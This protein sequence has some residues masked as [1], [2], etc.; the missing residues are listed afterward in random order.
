MLYPPRT[1]LSQRLTVRIFV[2]L[3]A[4]C[5]A[6]LLGMA[7]S[8]FKW[9][10]YPKIH[11]IYRQ[12][13]AT[14]VE[15]EQLRLLEHANA[16][17]LISLTKSG[18][19]QSIRKRLH[20]VLWGASGF[21][22]PHSRGRA[23]SSIQSPYA[24]GA[25]LAKTDRITVEMQHG[26]NSIAF[27]FYPSTPNDTLVVYQQGHASEHGH[28]KRV[29]SFFLE[30]GHHVL[31]LQLPLHGGNSQ[32]TVVLGKLGAIQITTH[33]QLRYLESE[34]FNPLKLFFEPVAISLNYAL[35]VHS[36]ERI[37]MVGISGGAWVT[38]VYAA[39]DE[40]IAQ[41]YPVA[42][43]APLFVRFA[44]PRAFWGDYEQTHPSLYK[45]A[46]Q[47]EMY[48]MASHGKLRKQVLIFNRYDPC[49]FSGITHRTY[50]SAVMSKVGDFGD[51]SF[52][53]WLDESH[54]EH[55]ISDDALRFIEAHIMGR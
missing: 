41:S 21:P 36:F 9:T 33:D 23:E 2:K 6:I 3:L 48:V 43:S 24:L 1:V 37:A 29:I 22:V 42:G 30:R 28:D 7:I 16:A 27:L 26:F 45:V 34:Q 55:K 4:V 15:N 39:L 12:M 47:L 46:N 49:C 8:H 25:V 40:R 44:I 20:N 14:R 52:S 5:I 53:V 51:G 17:S 31:S 38:S 35:A 19:V 11:S 18:E 10:P 50:E 32:P 54:H 13:T